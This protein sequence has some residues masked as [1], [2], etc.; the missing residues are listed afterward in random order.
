MRFSIDVER[1]LV[2]SVAE[3]VL[4][5]AAVTEH[6]RGL[7]ADPHFDP[8]F[9]QLADFSQVT[10]VRLSADEIQTLAARKVFA[11]GSRRAGVAPD[12]LVYAIGRMYDAYRRLSGGKEEGRVF[13]T[14]AEALQWLG[15]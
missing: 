8:T 2:T 9:N 4:D 10:E 11:A 1:R 6:M 12:D 13:R 7:L 14:R 5:F 15:P 3:G